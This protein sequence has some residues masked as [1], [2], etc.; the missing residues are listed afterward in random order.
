LLRPAQE[1]KALEAFKKFVAAMK[2]LDDNITKRNDNPGSK[3]RS[4]VGSRGY[5]YNLLR[6]H[7]EAGPTGRGVPY[8]TTI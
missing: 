6:P 2:T 3:M 1:K 4:A 7:S 5:Q 8:S